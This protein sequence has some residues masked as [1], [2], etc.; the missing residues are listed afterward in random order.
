M[1][2]HLAPPLL[3]RKD[4]RTGEPRKMRF[5][6]WMMP[7]VQDARQPEGPARH[8]ARHLR[9][10]R[11]AAH[12][13]RADRR[14]RG[15]GRAPARRPHAAEPRARGRDRLDAR[16]RS[17]ASA[18]SRSATSARRARNGSS[19]WRNTPPDRP[20]SAPPLE[21]AG[22]RRCCWPPRRRW[23]RNGWSILG[24][25][26]RAR[27]RAHRHQAPRRRR[28]RAGRR[29]FQCAEAALRAAARI[30]RSHR[31]KKNSSASSAGFSSPRIASSPRSRSDRDGCWCGSSASPTTSPG[32]STSRCDGKFL[33][34]DVP[35]QERDELRRVLNSSDR[36]RGQARFPTSCN[37]DKRA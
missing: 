15:D 27:H 10:H 7:R 20:R 22:W 32:S 6:P 13:A 4:P 29:A 33:L 8:R 16:R 25:R 14:I 37:A 24:A 30:P 36:S 19:C 2:F 11:G 17:A 34:D 18:T 9:L 21:G 26:Q 5:G 28:P 31:A 23:R 35:S 12:G 3:A 1:V